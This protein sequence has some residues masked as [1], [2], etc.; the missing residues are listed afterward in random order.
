MLLWKTLL[1]GVCGMLSSSLIPTLPSH[2]KEGLGEG[3]TWL[4]ILAGAAPI[5]MVAI[6]LLALIGFQACIAPSAPYRAHLRYLLSS[7]IAVLL[8][9]A[10]ARALPQDAPLTQVAVLTPG[11]LLG[12]WGWTM[13]I[14]N[15]H[16]QAH[17]QELIENH[18]QQDP[19]TNVLNHHTVHEV[20]ERQI[21]EALSRDQSL[22][23]AILDVRHFALYNATHG[24]RAGDR[25]LHQIATTLRTGLP[26]HAVMGRYDADAFLLILPSTTRDEAVAFVQHLCK[27]VRQ[28]EYA[29]SNGG[30][31]LP[32]AISA[33]VAVFPDDG[34]TVQTLLQ[35]AEG[36]SRAA[37]HSDTD[38]APA[39]SYCHPHCNITVNGSFSAL[40]AMITAIDRKDRY[41]HQHSED[42]T[43]FA[44]W[45]A[46][47]VGLPEDQKQILEIATLVHDVGKIAIP[48][49]VLL[50]PDRL[51]KVEYEVVQ[52]H[53][54]LGAAILSALQNL[55][56]VVPIVRSHHEHWNGRGY[57]DRLKGE[58][59]PYLARILAVADAFS[60]MTTDRPYR[61][62]MNW[63]DAFAEL[64]KQKGKQFD[65]YIVD[66][67]T[68]AI[69]KRTTLPMDMPT[70]SLK[71]A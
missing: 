68:A 64:H 63:E 51:T 65:P 69:K 30:E 53:P 26:P 46:E 7:V 66:A 31:P 21:D 18:R 62:G 58:Q 59:I 22:A 47:E 42:V 33:G 1:L 11:V 48:D 45:I 32:I 20:L 56:E 57:P 27:Q 39:S 35:A 49:E 4:L 13:W 40:Q 50:K 54:T 25:L 52:Q 60:A 43:K 24:R 15:R 16:L 10:A 34:Q 70:S 6:S 71:A 67:F 17:L 37:I 5:T 23:I 19:L 8:V 44:L 9:L 3:V 12:L 36:A 2:V 29:K 61:K 14:R 38:V 55:E 28:T 41:T